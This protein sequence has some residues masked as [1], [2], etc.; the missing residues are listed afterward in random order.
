MPY[1][2]Q[3]PAFPSLQNATDVIKL[4]NPADVAIFFPALPSVYVFNVQA[5]FNIN[6]T[7]AQFV[8]LV[9]STGSLAAFSNVIAT[10][11]VL[12]LG[13]E[14]RPFSALRVFSTVSAMLAH[15]SLAVA[16]KW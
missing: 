15:T 7:S 9:R 11:G 8:P 3:Y 13:P 14:A 1:G 10:L 16:I 5:A 12:N 4:P 2:T 6:P